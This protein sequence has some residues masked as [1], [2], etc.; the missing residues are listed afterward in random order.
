MK[1]HLPILIAVISLI[2]AGAAVLA[3]TRRNARTTTPMSV[4]SPTVTPPVE[5]TPA[6]P[7]KVPVL[8]SPTPEFQNRVTKKPFG[9]YST[10]ATSP[11][12]PER[13]TGYH[14]AVDIEYADAATDVPVVAIAD[15]EIVMAEWVS[16]YG[17]LIVEK[18]VVNGETLFI[19]YGHMDPSSFTTKTTVKQGEQIA[20]L[21]DGYTT[22]TDGE[23]KHIHFGIRKGSLDIRGYV[24]SEGELAGWY[25][26]I[27]FYQSVN[28]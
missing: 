18:I 2:L 21:G 9:L 27:A 23:R 24:Q 25:D 26:P 5:P 6:P 3:L 19:I 28:Q 12:Q 13:F 16:G 10:P 7:A 20:I 15:G 14:N 11:V 17:G 4:T 22:E 1:K 8:V